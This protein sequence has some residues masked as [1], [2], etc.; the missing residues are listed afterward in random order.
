MN[1][2]DQRL[3]A[4]AK[5]MHQGYSVDRVWELTRIDKWFLTRLKR[6]VDFEI[7]LKKYSVQTITT[8]AI[9]EA[10]KLGFSDRQVAKVLSTNELAIRKLR[11]EMGVT[12]FVKQIDTGNSFM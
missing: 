10:K 8:S 3:F 11:K 5:A 7:N 4:I 2:S 1:P 6:I 12:P 9:W